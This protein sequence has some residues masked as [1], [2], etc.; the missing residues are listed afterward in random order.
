M[1]D[2]VTFNLLNQEGEN[3]SS[4]DFAGRRLVMFFYPA[5]M[6]PGCT[7]ESCDFRDSYSEFTAAGYDIVGVSPDPPSRN[8][9][10]REKEGLN[11]DLLSDE[12]HALA[13]E[14]GAWGEKKMYGVARDGLIRSTFV[15]G[16]D[17]HV[18]KAYRNVK[19]TGHVARVKQDL[20]G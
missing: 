11:F 12:D 17:G 20:L 13:E 1:T 18:E 2:T 9:K 19:A 4:D 15:V 14:L 6:T 8:A 16:P 7:Q 5:A 10:F 3:V